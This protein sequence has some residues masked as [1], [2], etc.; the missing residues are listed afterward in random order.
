MLIFQITICD[1]LVHI[2]TLITIIRHNEIPVTTLDDIYILYH[3]LF[4]NI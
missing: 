1:R 2:H 4:T 3:D